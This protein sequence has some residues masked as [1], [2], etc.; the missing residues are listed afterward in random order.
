MVATTTAT[1]SALLLNRKT[2]PFKRLHNINNH[3]YR[4]LQRSFL[5]PRCKSIRPASP[6]IAAANKTTPKQQQPANPNN[7]KRDENKDSKKKSVRFAPMLQVRDLYRTPTDLRHS[8]YHAAEYTHFDRERRDT[9]AALAQVGGCARYLDPTQYTLLG[10]ERHIDR[11]ASWRRKL[12]TRQHCHAILQA[13]QRH[14]AGPEE[15]RAV[16]EYFSKQQQQQPVRGVLD[17]A[18]H[19]W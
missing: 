3:N 10:L 9:V 19:M 12:A 15:L 11:Q 5:P 1:R 18:L 17:S 13:Q 6:V 8:W 2:L 14:C 16:S 4:S 7:S